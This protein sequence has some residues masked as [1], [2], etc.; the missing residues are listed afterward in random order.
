[1]CWTSCAGPPVCW[2]SC[3]T[4]W[5]Y[6]GAGPRQCWWQQSHSRRG[7]R[8][9]PHAELDP[10][11]ADVLVRPAWR[12]PAPDPGG[13]VHSGPGKQETRMIKLT[14]ACCG[15]TVR[16]TANGSTRATRY[17][18]TASPCTTSDTNPEPFKCPRS[19][20]TGGV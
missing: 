4:C 1:M 3:W 13:K 6:L 9:V 10:A 11:A 17:A 19:S 15:Y 8:P 18:P 20:R 12:G 5:T 2:T 16:T 14:A 7:P